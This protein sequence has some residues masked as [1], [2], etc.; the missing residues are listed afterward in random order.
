MNGATLKA[1]RS[2]LQ[3]SQDEAANLIGDVSTKSWN[4]WECGDRTIPK[5]VI[6]KIHFLMDW[7]SR[8]IKT[9]LDQIKL[10][11]EALP[12]KAKDAPVALVWYSS[13]DD[14]ITVKYLNR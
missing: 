4:Y 13:I 5:D 8:A 10:M 12:P 14:W 6:H 3:F 1:A 7:R 11:R 2:L 9:A